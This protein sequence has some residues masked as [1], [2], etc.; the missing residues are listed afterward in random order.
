[1]EEEGAVIAGRLASAEDEISKLGTDSQGL[2]DKYVEIQERQDGVIW[3]ACLT[4]QG[5]FQTLEGKVVD[6]NGEVSTLQSHSDTFKS[7]CSDKFTQMCDDDEQVKEQIKFLMESSEMLKRRA[8]EFNKTHASQLKELSTNEGKLAEQVAAME[9]SL[10][11]FEREL[12]AVEKR[13]RT[14]LAL[15]DCEPSPPSEPVPVDPNTHLKGVL[16]QLEH[17]AN[18]TAQKLPRPVGTGYGM[19]E[20]QDVALNSALAS[21]AALAPR[22]A[23][24]AVRTQGAYGLSPRVPL[25]VGSP[26]MA[27]PQLPR[28]MKSARS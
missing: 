3:K 16:V 24:S 18:G 10:K 25:P 6:L 20:G 4:L 8:R 14:A 19:P 22:G 17:I 28:T 26:G 2:A 15:Q 21:I 11:G 12:K 1:M 9:R 7:F 5:L 23:D 27:K 13:A